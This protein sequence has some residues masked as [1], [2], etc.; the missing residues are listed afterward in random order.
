MLL[1]QERLCTY[2][3]KDTTA[4]ADVVAT[5]SS[6]IAGNVM[7]LQMYSKLWNET[8]SPSGEYAADKLVC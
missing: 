1:Q 4:G 7:G 3:E 5:D 6:N 8:V 2:A